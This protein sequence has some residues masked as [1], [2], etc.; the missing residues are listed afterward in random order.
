M[1]RLFISHA[2]ENAAEA[3]AILQWLRRGGWEDVFFDRDREQGIQPGERWE[4]ALVQ[5]AS[6]CEAVLF[7]ISQAWLDS[8]WCREEFDLARHL[9]K[10]LYA[11]IIS[12]DISVDALP[13]SL[14]TTWQAVDLGAGQDH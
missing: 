4:Q 5:A 10:S 1:P 14:K 11:T 3:V 8:G 12:S 9:K 7:L 2:G 13:E 6:Q